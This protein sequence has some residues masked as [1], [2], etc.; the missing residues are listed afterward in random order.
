M[1]NKSS[2]S[3]STWCPTKNYTLLGLLRSKR[4]NFLW[5]T[6][7]ICTYYLESFDALLFELS[8]LLLI[9]LCQTFLLLDSP[10]DNCLINPTVALS[11][12]I[13]SQL[14]ASAIDRVLVKY[15]MK[16]P[17]CSSECP[18]LNLMLIH[19]SLPIV[20]P[21]SVLHHVIAESYLVAKFVMVISL[22][23]GNIAGFM[24]CL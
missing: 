4:C 8:D 23:I 16:C 5:D 11:G 2:S 19:V 7:Y 12:H 22:K 14:L 20:V 13:V 21:N 6:L 24:N 1:I 18:S 10:D 3:L 17:S 9:G 15:K